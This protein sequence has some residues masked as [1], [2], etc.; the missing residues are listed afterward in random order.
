MDRIMKYIEFSELPGFARE[1]IC[2]VH[3]LQT[4]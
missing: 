4:W 3:I 1:G 2:H